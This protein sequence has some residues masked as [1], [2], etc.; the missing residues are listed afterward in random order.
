MTGQCERQDWR[1]EFTREEL[2]A[3]RREVPHAI[4][5][6]QERS[7]RAHTEYDDPDGDQDV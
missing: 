7:A 1:G 4:Q 2:C 3:I 6:S 5:R